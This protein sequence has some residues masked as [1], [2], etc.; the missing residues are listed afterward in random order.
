MR[1]SSVHLGPD[2]LCF[3][4]DGMPGIGISV[5]L[6]YVGLEIRFYKIA[7]WLHSPLAVVVLQQK[8][9]ISI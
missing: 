2:C 6:I 4:F 7:K 5:Q 1:L 3:P 8:S 9:S